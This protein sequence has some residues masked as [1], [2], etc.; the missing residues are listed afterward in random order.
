MD[1][2]SKAFVETIRNTG[3]QASEGIQS[4]LYRLRNIPSLSQ[5]QEPQFQAMP[6]STH[7]YSKI[8]EKKL[9]VLGD[10]L[11]N[12]SVSKKTPSAKKSSELPGREEF[13]NKDWPP[14]MPASLPEENSNPLAGE[15]FTEQFKDI[16]GE[17]FCQE[18]ARR[19]RTM[20]IFKEQLNAE[21]SYLIK[22]LGEENGNEEELIRRIQ[23]IDKKSSEYSDTKATWAST[24][25]SRYLFKKFGEEEAKKRELPLLA[26]LR[27][28]SIKFF[29]TEEINSTNRSAA[30]SDFAHPETNLMEM[31]DYLT[32]TDETK[33]SRPY[34]FYDYYKVNIADPVAKEHLIKEIK[35]RL[36]LA[37]G[38]SDRNQ[39]H[40]LVSERRAR[41]RSLMLQDLYVHF[42]VKPAK[43]RSLFYGR[44]ALLDPEKKPVTE[45]TGYQLNERNQLL[46]MKALYDELDG[47]KVIFDLDVG[48]YFDDEGRIHMPKSFCTDK[49]LEMAQLRTLLINVCVQG[50]K[51]NTGLQYTINKEAVDKMRTTLELTEDQRKLASKLNKALRQKKTSFQV[52]HKSIQF[53][54]AMGYCST[55]CYGGKDRTGYA[56]ALEIYYIIRKHIKKQRN[57]T[58]TKPKSDNIF[59]AKIAHQLI[60]PRA[61]IRRIIEDNSG[62]GITAIKVT[63]FNLKLFIPGPGRFWLLGI[64]KRLSEYV[65][66]G[67]LM[68][69]SKFRKQRVHPDKTILYN[70]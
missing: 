12:S 69:S 43:E 54:S 56:L 29:D 34:H 35:Q 37:Y 52:S 24:N 5:Q 41:L 62:T 59:M 68:V 40:I 45:S 38:T 15:L 23:T 48:T 28:H 49:K 10:Q 11:R 47:T 58:N 66:G 63:D 57:I 50:H 14:P 2:S 3:K 31:E 33:E 13:F 51:K 61:I 55:D 53:M 9:T 7:N 18:E 46:D 6:V 17:V 67:T 70:E 20:T 26:N 22:Q 19:A 64:Q 36:E 65:R 44:V 25:T 1:P 60:G 30:I 21:R 27:S 32:L 16:K 42:Q 8:G 4:I 39:I